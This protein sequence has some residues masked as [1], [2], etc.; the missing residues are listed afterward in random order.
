MQLSDLSTLW[1]W[2]KQAKNGVFFFF[3]L[4][5]NS[6]AANPELELELEFLTQAG[7]PLHDTIFNVCI[8]DQGRPRLVR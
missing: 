4:F 1:E 8:L 2:R 7:D 6:T 3:S 5:F